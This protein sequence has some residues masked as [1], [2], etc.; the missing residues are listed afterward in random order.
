[1]L[2][3]VHPKY[4][5]PGHGPVVLKEGVVEVAEE[6]GYELGETLLLLEDQKMTEFK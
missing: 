3:M 5:V 2:N 1:M 4:L 6:L